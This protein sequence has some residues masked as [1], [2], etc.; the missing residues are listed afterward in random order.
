MTT[1]Y[2]ELDND[3]LK[4]LVVSKGEIVARGRKHY[5]NMVELNDQGNAIAEER[6]VV[7]AQIL[8]K[9][10]ELLKDEKLGEFD[11]ATTTDIK[12][13]VLRVEIVDRVEQFKENMKEEKARAERKED[14]KETP[15]EAIQ[16]KQEEFSE[17]LKAI[18]QT[19]AVD[20]LDKLIAVL[21]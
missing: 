1:R 12:D 20:K 21:K 14:G 4:A 2:I 8:E 19:E 10:A 11:L 7:V 5:Q 15:E 18:P 17:L 16:S 3:E 9:T 13:D 6:N